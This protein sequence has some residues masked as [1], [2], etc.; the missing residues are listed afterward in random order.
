MSG[1]IRLDPG[2]GGRGFTLG[3][4]PAWGRTAGGVRRLWKTDV[5]GAA[6][7][8]DEPGGRIDAEIGYGLAAAPG[9]G[10]VAP[11]AGLEFTG[12]DARW[13]RMG[14]RWEVVSAASLSL[15]GTR[16]EAADDD[17]PKH[18]LMLRGGLRW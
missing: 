17:G 3:V 10:V 9:L 15:E 16:H 4:Q 11:Y 1:T 8:A 2:V 14:A 18:G 7:P 13:W 5:V 6:A 12:E